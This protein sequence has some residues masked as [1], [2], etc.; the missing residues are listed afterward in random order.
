MLDFLI[1]GQG[2][3]G[4]VLA[5]T[6]SKR[7]YKIAVID[8]P[9]LSS[10]SRVAGGVWNP[11]VFKRLTKSWMADELVPSLYKFY[12]NFEEESDCSFMYERL[13]I[14]P[15]TEEQEK[16]LWQKKAALENSFLDSSCYE[17]LPAR[18]VNPVL[19]YSHV[20]RAGNIDLSVFLPAVKTYLLKKGHTVLT[21]VFK[22]DDLEIESDSVKYHSLEA[23]FLVFCEGHRIA[24]NPWFKDIP[25][26]PAK[27]ETL[28]IHCPE[29]ELNNS[30]L[31]KGVFIMPLGNQVFKVG[32][33][34]EWTELN[35][36]PT[37]KGRE[38][39]QRKLELLIKV[40]Y[41]I[42][43]HN[44][45]V[46]PSVI[47]RRPVLGAHHDYKHLLLFNGLGTKGVMLAPYFSEKLADL[48]NK[49]EFLDKEINV[50]RF[51]KK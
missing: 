17:N 23:S 7:G 4:S 33:T 14:K 9:E 3:A 11:V 37:T 48:Y 42:L 19:S 2:I 35:D 27:G 5:L 41:T 28:T 12:R 24:F 15:F 46:R 50:S 44:A 26:K 51:Y 40:P 30:I 38:E 36:E 34:Y 16:I 47:D 20:L 31:N 32:A 8:Q 45:G 43:D 25:M 29:L 22:Y 13:I 10:S 39:L 21:E 18:G 6:L 49:P 1:V